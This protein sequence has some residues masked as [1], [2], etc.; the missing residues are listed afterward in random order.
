[1]AVALGLVAVTGASTLAGCGEDAPALPERAEFVERLVE[2]SDRTISQST[3]NCIYDRARDD[4]DLLRGLAEDGRL[5][6]DQAA[7]RDE[8]VAACL[9]SG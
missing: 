2:G 6:E 9:T 5:T 8:I 3:A 1:V 7:R 4:A